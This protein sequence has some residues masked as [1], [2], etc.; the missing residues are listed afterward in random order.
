MRRE[1]SFEEILGDLH[2]SDG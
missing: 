1:D 2:A